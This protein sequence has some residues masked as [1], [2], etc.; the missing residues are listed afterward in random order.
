MAPSNHTPLAPTGWPMQQAPP[1]TF[2]FSGSMP[3]SFIKSKGTAAKASLVSQRS[4]SAA[5]S[6]VLSKTF[7]DTTQTPYGAILGSIPA[8]ATDLTV[9]LGFKSNS[10]AFSFD[11]NIAAA[12]PS[13]SLEELAALIFPSGL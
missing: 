13:V 2:T 1:L 10:L 7:L 11:M 3:I 12:A 4:I 5:D 6:P 9:P 8:Q